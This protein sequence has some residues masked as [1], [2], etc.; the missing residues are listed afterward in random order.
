MI[1]D[2]THCLD[3]EH[4]KLPDCTGVGPG[5]D[6]QDPRGTAEYFGTED[7]PGPGYPRP[8]RRE[9]VSGPAALHT[10]ELP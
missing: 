3:V 7:R 8:R 5:A 6:V 1:I 9:T 2:T 10:R 4:L